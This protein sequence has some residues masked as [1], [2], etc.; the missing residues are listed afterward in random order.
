MRIRATPA[1]W[2]HA[3]ARTSSVTLIEST[4]SSSFLVVSVNSLFS[5]VIV[6]NRHASGG[7]LIDATLKSFS[8]SSWIYY[9]CHGLRGLRYAVKIWFSLFH[10][11]IFWCRRKQTHTSQLSCAWLNVV[12]SA[13]RT[14]GRYWFLKKGGFVIRASFFSFGDRCILSWVS[15]WPKHRHEPGDQVEV[16]LLLLSLAD[17]ADRICVCL[18]F[19]RSTCGCNGCLWYI[20]GFIASYDEA[21]FRW[22]IIKWPSHLSRYLYG[23]YFFFRRIPYGMEAVAG[24]RGNTCGGVRRW[25]L[26]LLSIN[27][28]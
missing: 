11:L 22:T 19:H 8:G 2:A 6:P 21:T 16:T 10:Y 12:A 3:F 15:I 18:N 23:V 20:D 14:E 17:V 27:L 1:P 4:L 24:C 28:M 25:R 13:A 9:G 26:F 5:Y 7:K